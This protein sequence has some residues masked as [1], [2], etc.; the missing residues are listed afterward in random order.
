MTTAR[1]SCELKRPDFGNLGVRSSPV[2]GA[3][4]VGDSIVNPRG[5]QRTKNDQQSAMSTTPAVQVYSPTL[6]PDLLAIGAWGKSPEYR[7]EGFIREKVASRGLGLLLSSI[8]SLKVFNHSREPVTISVMLE[9]PPLIGQGEV[10][11]LFLTFSI[12][13]CIPQSH[14]TP[15]PLNH[16][17]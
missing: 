4:G 5:N 15:K 13:C 14:F 7:L 10:H 2:A 3:I 9:S 11:S 16:Q 17:L 6:V 12:K 1:F 8:F